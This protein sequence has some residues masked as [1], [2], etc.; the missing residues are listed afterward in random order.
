MR[1]KPRCYNFYR[2]SY[3]NNQYSFGETL[4]SNFKLI[5]SDKISDE[6]RHVCNVTPPKGKHI[7]NKKIV[8]IIKTCILKQKHVFH[9]KNVV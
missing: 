1:N 7:F 6:K 5:E 9:V 8:F 3:D 2:Q 4:F